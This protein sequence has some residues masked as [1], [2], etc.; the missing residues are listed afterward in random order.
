MPAEGWADHDLKFSTKSLS[1]FPGAKS[2]GRETG[3][4]HPSMLSGHFGGVREF[5]E[6]GVSYEMDIHG[7]LKCASLIHVTPS[8]KELQPEQKDAGNAMCFW[9]VFYKMKSVPAYVN[10]HFSVWSLPEET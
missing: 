5:L 4:F 3:L 8:C 7:M 1:K 10:S 9:R 2:F 6:G